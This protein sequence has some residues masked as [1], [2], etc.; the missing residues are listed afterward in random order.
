M[1]LDLVVLHNS[2]MATVGATWTRS[3]NYQMITQTTHSALQSQPPDT[4]G[5]TMLVFNCSQ[6]GFIATACAFTSDGLFQ[7]E[8]LHAT[9]TVGL[10]RQGNGSLLTL[11]PL[12]LSHMGGLSCN[13]PGANAQRQFHCFIVVQ[14]AGINARSVL[15][16]KNS[17]AEYVS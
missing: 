13:K 4:L 11:T 17:T 2:K 9:G 16:W 7:L 5:W 8:A 10:L 14:N 12:H 15:A 1:C 6:F 3:Q